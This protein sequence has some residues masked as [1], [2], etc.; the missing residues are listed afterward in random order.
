[1]RQEE[2]EH[3]ARWPRRDELVGGRDPSRRGHPA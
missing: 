1:V 2:L 3:G